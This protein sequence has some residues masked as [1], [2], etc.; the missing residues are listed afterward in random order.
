[1][2]DIPVCIDISHHQGY[3]DFDEVRRSGVR[4]VIHKATEGSSFIDDARAENLANAKNAGLA[5]ATYFWLKPGDGRSQAEFYLSV[6]DPVDGE[7]VVI[8]Y[9]EDNCSLTTLKDAIQALLDYGRNLQ[10]TVYS[11]HLLKEQLGDHHDEYLA[12]HTDLWLAQY[13][14]DESNISWPS[15]TYPQWSL[16]QYS[17][18]G[19]IPGIDD[20]YV[21]LDNFNGTDANFLK[22]I[23]TKGGFPMPVPPPEPSE[24]VRVAITAPEHVDMRVSI[25]GRPARRPS[26]L[27]K[28]RRGPDVLR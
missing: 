17:E 11:G 19:E 16:W 21:D 25:N 15:G 1:M 24:L 12:E 8:D 5:I 26:I 6:I 3:P 10:I 7:R 22:W 14:S 23:N 20:S 18:I 28:A 27:R 9:E 13:T 2:S 4:G